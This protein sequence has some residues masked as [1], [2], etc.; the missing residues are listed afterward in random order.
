MALR[1]IAIDWS[2]AER[3]AEKHI[4]LAEIDPVDRRV[5]RLEAGRSRAAIADHLL[6][7]ARRTPE[8]VV[9]LDFAFSLPGWFLDDRAIADAFALWKLVDAEGEGWLAECVPPFWGRPGTRRPEL[10]DHFRR[11]DRQVPAVGGIRPKSVFQIGGA[12]AVGTGSIRGMPILRRLREEGQFAVWPFDAPRLPLVLEIYPRALTGVVVKAS[13]E[14]RDVYL[15][16]HFPGLDERVRQ[17]A[18]SSEDAFDALVSGLAMAEHAS[19]FTA[20]PPADDD[21]GRREGRIWLSGTTPMPSA[22]RRRQFD[23]SKT[24]VAPAFNALKARESEDPQWVASLLDLAARAD[25]PDRPWRHQDLTVEAHYWEPNERGLQP[26]V[27]LLSW[28]IRN[29]A[30]VPGRLTA[31]GDTMDRRRALAARDPDTIET[32]LESLRRGGTGKAWHLLEG[33]SYPDAFL[34]TRDAL[35]VVEGKRTEAGPTTETYWMPG[36]HQIFRHLDAAWEIRGR[37]AVYGLF[38][39]EADRE[40]HPTD[41]P[42]LWQSAA[43]TTL[44]REAIDGSLPHR[45]AAE[46]REIAGAFVGVTT[47]QMIVEAFQLPPGTL[48]DRAE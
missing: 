1:I 40:I 43:D 26:P 39:V 2:G 41:V 28:L 13:N 22:G 18:V 6:E 35:I 8:L 21:T 17:L 14:G 27:A 4:W 11:T 15:E 32:A 48:L 7:E 37:R 38:V 20:L 5:V 34:V 23:S 36:R 46:Q 45:G 33:P 25:Q 42:S 47:W 30:P 19:G 16:A 24:R 29:F 3:G 12:G 31:D 9:G 10:P 44:S